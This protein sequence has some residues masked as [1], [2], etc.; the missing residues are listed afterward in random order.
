MDEFNY[1]A[2]AEVFAYKT[3]GFGSR[4]LTYQRFA[5]SAS[6]IRF[7]IEVLPSKLLPSAVLEANEHRFSAKQISKLYESDTYPYERRPR[8]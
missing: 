5:D 2:P 3:C 1:G 4:V 6:A 7:M 8:S